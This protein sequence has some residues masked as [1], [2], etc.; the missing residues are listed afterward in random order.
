MHTKYR[1]NRRQLL[2]LCTLLLLVP[3]L[4][5]LPSATAAAAGRAAWFSAPA[6][7]P[8][9]LLYLRFLCRFM[10][11]RREGEGLA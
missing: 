2:S 10:E 8:P 3:A 11:L 7:L 9:L 4:R 6:A 5:L 1:F